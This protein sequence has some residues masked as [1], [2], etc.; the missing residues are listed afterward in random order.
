MRTLFF[1]HLF[2]IY[3][4]SYSIFELEHLLQTAN[5]NPNV[6]VKI[7]YDIGCVL[8]SHLQVL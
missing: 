3:R 2:L 5:T 6:D 4:I 7:M 1:I 8:S